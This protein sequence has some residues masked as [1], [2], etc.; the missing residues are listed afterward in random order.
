MQKYRPF[1]VSN[2]LARHLKHH[3]SQTYLF[4]NPSQQNNLYL[5][6]HLS[7]VASVEK[8]GYRPSLSIIFNNGN[9]KELGRTTGVSSKMANISFSY[10][11]PPKNQ[12]HHSS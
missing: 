1:N 2:F 6:N 8:I 10:T 7:E 5:S 12:K 11:S 3:N 9:R 4:N